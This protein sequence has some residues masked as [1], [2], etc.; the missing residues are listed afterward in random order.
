M[1]IL[2][3]RAADVTDL[4]SFPNTRCY[5]NKKRN[6][7]KMV[8]EKVLPGRKGLGKNESFIFLWFLRRF[9]VKLANPLLVPLYSFSLHELWFAFSSSNSFDCKKK[10]KHREGRKVVE[11]KSSPWMGEERRGRRSL[12]AFIIIIIL[13][14]NENQSRVPWTCLR[15][16]TQWGSFFHCE[17]TPFVLSRSFQALACPPI[18]RGQAASNY[19]ISASAGADK[20]RRIDPFSFGRPSTC[21]ALSPPKHRQLFPPRYFPRSNEKFDRVERFS[22]CF[23]ST[24][25]RVFLLYCVFHKDRD[26]TL[27]EARLVS[28]AF[29]FKPTRLSGIIRKSFCKD[30]IYYWTKNVLY[31]Q[32]VQVYGRRGR[33][34]Y[35]YAR[36]EQISRTL[37]VYKTQQRRRGNCLMG[38]IRSPE[39][40]PVM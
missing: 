20:R 16:D 34:T 26:R 19:F 29:A 4:F 39:S 35:L 22:R 31:R 18:I 28:Q 14:S 32:F 5:P 15:V 13:F 12:A 11:T 38:S 21:I 10:E 6:A 37:L 7:K 24:S 2:Q 33:N 3:L 8:E 36:F 17:P 30:Y 27:S 40:V 25:N 1:R 23:L 9:S